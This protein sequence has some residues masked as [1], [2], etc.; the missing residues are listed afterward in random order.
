MRNDTGSA[1][2]FSASDGI[3]DLALN[4]AF[5]LSMTFNPTASPKHKIYLQRSGENVNTQLTIGGAAPGAMPAIG[6]AAN[7]G[8]VYTS[9]TI[10][11]THTIV[12]PAAPVVNGE[13]LLV[14][15]MARNSG[16]GLGITMSGGGWATVT[17][18]PFANAAGDVVLG[19][20][21]K[22]A[23]GGESGNIPT[24]VV[25]TGAGTA[26]TQR[27]LARCL[28]FTAT[29]GFAANPF[30][31]IVATDKAFNTTVNAPTVTTTAANRRAVSIVALS[32]NA[33]N[34]A[35][36]FT[37]ETGGD[38][39]QSTNSNFGTPPQAAEFQVQTA[40]L[41]SAGT[42]TGG[43]FDGG[44]NAAGKVVGFALVP[45]NVAATFD[46]SDMTQGTLQ[47]FNDVVLGAYNGSIG[48]MTGALQRLIFWRGAP[49]LSD[50]D[51]LP[52]PQS[53]TVTLPTAGRSAGRRRLH[54]AEHRR[55]L[56]TAFRSIR[57]RPRAPT[58]PPQWSR[59]SAS[60][61]ARSPPP[62]FSPTARRS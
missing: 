4:Q 26:G 34:V 56:R 47:N 54:G 8:T 12:Y 13:L 36:S 62:R 48:F 57:P 44:A 29:N 38:W 45:A 11:A 15:A 43:S 37:T 9:T 5:L 39:I 50:L 22:I 32:S 7:H 6:A 51:A 33:M 16:G 19:L 30:E 46:E 40:A 58:P 28:R 18:S 14:V 24:G 61:T 35:Q 41:G 49:S 42:I 53:I 10:A 20:F 60:A 59:S 17:G 3:V 2:R 23:A 27:F 25:G 21:W 55:E 52:N 1:R 31:G